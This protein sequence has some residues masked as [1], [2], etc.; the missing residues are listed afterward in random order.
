MPMF[1]SIPVYTLNQ[2]LRF[3]TLGGHTVMAVSSLIPWIARQDECARWSMFKSRE[4]SH[5]RYVWG[6]YCG[7][8]NSVLL[9]RTCAES[10]DLF[11]C[12][13]PSILHWRCGLVL[14]GSERVVTLITHL[15]EYIYCVVQSG[16]QIIHDGHRDRSAWR[17]CSQAP[18]QS[19]QRVPCVTSI[20]I[21]TTL[22]LVH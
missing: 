7:Q 8:W 22:M 12:P 2:L 10:L 14:N 9:C 21:F 4:I 19:K 15:L 3:S 6:K 18:M 20:F 11:C 16:T 1:I 17:I 5:T 13:Q